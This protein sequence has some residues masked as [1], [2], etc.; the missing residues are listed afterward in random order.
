MESINISLA[1]KNHWESWATQWGLSGALLSAVKRTVSASVTVCTTWTL[2]LLDNKVSSSCLCCTSDERGENRIHRMVFFCL[3]VA[4]MKLLGFFERPMMAGR[5]GTCGLAVL[6]TGLGHFYR[7]DG[8]YG[9]KVSSLREDLLSW[10][11]LQIL[12]LLASGVCSLPL[13]VNVA[14]NYC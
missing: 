2:F 9:M 5:F 1:C 10:Y 13:G 14:D 3:S 11:L 7:C 8:F 6:S 4:K 12:W